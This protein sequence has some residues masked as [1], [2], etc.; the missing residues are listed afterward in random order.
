MAATL[1]LATASVF[2]QMA[3]MSKPLGANSQALPSYLKNAGLEQRLNQ[4]LPL[5][6]TF[7]DESGNSVAL[8]DYFQHRPVV[9][10]LVYFN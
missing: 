6:A 7:L 4:P 1:L 3:D 2:G 8:G 10:A 5:T 9:M